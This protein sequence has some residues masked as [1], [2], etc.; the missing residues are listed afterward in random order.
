MQ[1]TFPNSISVSC[2]SGC[3]LK[4]RVYW[5]ACTELPSKTLVGNL[6]VMICSL[7]GILMT[8]NVARVWNCS[9]DLKCEM[10][11]VKIT[12]PSFLLKR[13]LCRHNLIRIS[14]SANCSHRL[15]ITLSMLSVRIFCLN[16]EDVGPLQQ[17]REELVSY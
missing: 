9:I 11:P 4:F 2:S 1:T 3:C 17:P 16:A 15:Y 14:D 13:S 8:R 6:A 7:L 10:G 5:Q 12:S